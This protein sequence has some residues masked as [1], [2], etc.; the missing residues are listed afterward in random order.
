MNKREP[1]ENEV[2]P[3]EAELE[4][5]PGQLFVFDQTTPKAIYTTEMLLPEPQNFL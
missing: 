3:E 5:E 2:T 1:S 4:T